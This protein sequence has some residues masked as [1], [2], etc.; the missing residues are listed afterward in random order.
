MS[1]AQR[2]FQALRLSDDDRRRAI[3]ADE[4]A[5][6]S[7]EET[8]IARS[9]AVAHDVPFAPATELIG[10][11]DV[12]IAERV[13]HAFREKHRLA[14]IRIDGDRALVAGDGPPDGRR[15]LRKMLDVEAIDWVVT[16]PSGLA[17]VHA[18]ID[19]GELTRAQAYTAEEPGTTDDLLAH[20]GDR[21]ADAVRVLE[22][23]LIEAAAERASDVHLESQSTRARVRVRVDGSLRELGH[24]D[25]RPRQLAPVVRIAKVRA[26]IDIADHRVPGGGQFEMRVGGQL[27]FVRVQSQPTVLGENLMMRLLPQ[28]PRLQRIEDL[29]FGEDAARLYRRRLN[30]PGGLV[31]VV[32]PTGSGK[33]TTLYAGLREL[34]SDGRRKVI[35]IEDPVETVCPEAQ[36]VQTCAETGF[37]FADAMRAFVREDPDAILVGEVRDPDTAREAIR[38]SQTGHVVLTSLHAN[39]AV[40][41]VQRLRDLGMHPN[42]IAT[43]LSAIFA[44]RLAPRICEACRRPAEPDPEIAREVFGGPPPA[45]LR[46]F[47]GEGCARCRESGR[48]GRVAIVESLPATPALRRAIARDDVVDDL[49]DVARTTG[50]VSL[51]DHAL[52]LVRAGVVA[53]DDLPRVIPLERLAPPSTD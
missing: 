16:T 13:P 5:A 33:T 31:L 22:S 47:E 37:G 4:A 48:H 49:R 12:A 32:G 15:R 9:L 3:A 24:F 10:A 45:D 41:A 20:D 30:N 52:D 29:G 19:V 23:I 46:V 2:L 50:L 1:L 21:Q 44:Q 26:G 27:Y 14:P 40:D 25:L 28:D 39:D 11:L 8:E 6:W 51:R 34:V 17:R 18:A 36:Q 35:T 7:D 53:F 43:E 38:A 42:S